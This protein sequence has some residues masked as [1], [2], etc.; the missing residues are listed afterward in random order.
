MPVVIAGKQSRRAAAHGMA[1]ALALGCWLTPQLSH[2]ASDCQS[3]S[4]VQLFDEGRKLYDLG[5]FEEAAQRWEQ[6]YL[7][8]GSSKIIFNLAQAQR[9]AGNAR[10]ALDLYQ[11]WLDLAPTVSAEE[12]ADVEQKIAALQVVAQRDR[13][14]VEATE[15]EAKLPTAEPASLP[16]AVPSAL[17]PSYPDAPQR[18]RA[19]LPLAAWYEDGWGWALAGTGIVAAS[20]GIVWM[21]AD[22][23]NAAVADDRANPATLGGASSALLG[24]ALFGAGVVKLL[25][26][27]GSAGQEHSA[28]RSA[29]CL[30]G[31]F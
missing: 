13:E 27:D 28:K 14:A 5:R 9:R 7:E 25:I 10:R 29:P 2:A 31:T 4:S 19:S 30:C 20:A 6:A 1:W 8:C 24:I 12:R 15:H 16:R 17:Q 23:P 26:V 22:E 11:R 3:Q 21:T 18:E